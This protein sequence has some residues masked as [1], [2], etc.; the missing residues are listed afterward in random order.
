MLGQRS[1]WPRCIRALKAN[2]LVTW[3]WFFPPKSRAE[4]SLGTGLTKKLR[5]NPRDWLGIKQLEICEL[6]S[7][8]GIRR[9]ITWR[10]KT[11]KRTVRRYSS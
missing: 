8:Q 7:A 9:S 1:G 4:Q 5:Q 6:P 11:K 10:P 3:M 2:R